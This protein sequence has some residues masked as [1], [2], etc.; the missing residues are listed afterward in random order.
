M[1]AAGGVCATTLRGRLRLRRRL[2]LPGRELPGEGRR[3]RAVHGHQPVRRGADLQG[4]RLLRERVRGQLPHL[5]RR[6]PGR[7]LRVVASADDPDSC[8]ADTRTCDAAGACKL[9]DQQP[10]AAAGDCAG[11][12]CTTLYPDADGDSFGDRGATVANGKAKGLLRR[13]AAAGWVT[14]N[15]DCCDAGDTNKAVHPGQT[16]WFTDAW[17]VRHPVRLRLRRH[18]RGPV[19]GG[20]AVRSDD[21][22]CRIR[23]LHRVRR[24]GR[25]PDLRSGHAGDSA[26]RPRP[27]LKVATDGADQGGSLKRF[28]CRR[29]IAVRS[30]CRPA[31]SVLNAIRQRN[32]S[33]AF[34]FERGVRHA[35]SK[36]HR[37]LILG[38]CLSCYVQPYNPP[39][40]QPGPSGEAQPAPAAPHDQTQPP[41]AE[42][43]PPQQPYAQQPGWV[44]QPPPPRARAPPASAP[45]YS[46][47]IYDTVNVGVAGNDVPSIDVFYNDLAPYGSWYNDPTY[48]WVFAP[49]SPSYVPYSNG[50]WAYTDYGYTWQS[51]DP[52]GWATDHYGRWVWANRWV[53]RPDTTWG[54]AWVQWREGD[55]Y[56]GW[57]PAGYT[58][59]AYVP[60]DVVALRRRRQPVRA[61]RAPLLRQRERRRLPARRG[62]RAPLRS[63]RQP[64]LGRRP[65]RRLAAPLPRAAAPRGV[66]SGPLRPL[67][68]SAAPARP[69][70]ARAS[71][72]TTGT[73]AA[74]RTSSSGA[75]CSR[76]SSARTRRAGGRPSTSA[77]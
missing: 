15:T 23:R 48:G 46:G 14:N 26:R 44:G 30:A 19:P 32:V 13:R 2:H 5:Q 42:Q 77:A 7:P 51:A 66:R 31:Y 65:E 47:P 60:D 59:D 63:P 21:V 57:A 52:F 36:H 45:V 40:A 50:H 1:C 27:R 29:R 76:A 10:C 41:P 74:G 71:T 37:L 3:R 69:N 39:P 55:G 75:T 11:G 4:R 8:P 16:A 12:A 33:G 22:Q 64:D 73:R 62:S 24:D 43:P 6:G 67:Q 38:G 54:P 25:L 68:R 58:D 34:S 17:T 70:G 61:R 56:V 20:R 72:S 9:K 49:P 18:D 53:W 28:I 35:R